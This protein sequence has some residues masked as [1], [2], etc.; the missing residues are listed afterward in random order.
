MMAPAISGKS[1]DI[2]TTLHDIDQIIP[3]AMSALYFD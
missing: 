3:T 1:G 2:P